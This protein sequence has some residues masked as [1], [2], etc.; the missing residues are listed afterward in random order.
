LCITFAFGGGVYAVCSTFG[1]IQNGVG[2]MEIPMLLFAAIFG[3]LYLPIKMTYRIFNRKRATEKK[4]VNA[5]VTID[6]SEFPLR[7][8]SDTGSTLKEPVSGRYVMLVD[9]TAL[10]DKVK[11]AGKRG[12]VIVPFVSAGNPK[13]ILSGIFA[14]NVTV[15]GRRLP[16][17][18]IA[19]V[20]HILSHSGEFDAVISSE[21]LL[22][23]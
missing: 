12:M 10:A 15:E 8:L 4:T 22:H 5:L 9:G 13:G 11:M 18:V 14:D 6:G 3:I 16:K 21:A 2:Y 19:P 17:T 7:L 1:V 20:G 23:I